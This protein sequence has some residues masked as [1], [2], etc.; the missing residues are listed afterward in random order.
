MWVQII[1][2]F[3]NFNGCTV[4]FWGWISNFIPLFKLGVITY[5]CQLKGPG[6]LES[7]R[8]PCNRPRFDTRGWH[9]NIDGHSRLSLLYKSH[10]WY[11][12]VNFCL[13][14]NQI[15]HVGLRYGICVGKYQLRR[16]IDILIFSVCYNTPPPWFLCIQLTLFWWRK[17]KW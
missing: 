13:I 8:S 3:P 5:P 2:P 17:L 1:H 12:T 4:E 16:K 7:N 11:M 10:S 6:K 9:S 14:N 15:S